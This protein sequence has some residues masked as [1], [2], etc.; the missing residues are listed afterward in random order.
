MLVQQNAVFHLTDPDTSVA[1]YDVSPDA[2]YN[3][4]RTGKILEMVCDRYGDL[5]KNLVQDV[6][7]L[8]H[9]TISDLIDVFKDGSKREANG[10]VVKEEDDDDDFGFN[11]NGIHVNGVNGNGV[12]GSKNDDDERSTTRQAYLLLARLIAAGIL[13]PVSPMMFQSPTDLKTAIEQG[14][15]KASFPTGIRGI[16]QKKE[17][18]VAV[19]ERV[20]DFQQ[21]RTRL[22]RSLEVEFDHEASVKRRKLLNGNSTSNGVSGTGAVDLLEQHVSVSREKGIFL[23]EYTDRLF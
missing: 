9:I 15:L 13:E 8:G 14:V 5:A 7:V 4:V 2:L 1:Y 17:L 22:K 3:L 21:G 18:E 6:L 20:K 11:G 16:K 12:N 19:A 10:F 23:G